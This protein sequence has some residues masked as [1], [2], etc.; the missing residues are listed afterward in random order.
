MDGV[1][2][3]DLVNMTGLPED[4]AARL[5]EVRDSVQALWRDTNGKF[6]L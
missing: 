3:H 6:V 2:N 4:E 1:Q 5:G